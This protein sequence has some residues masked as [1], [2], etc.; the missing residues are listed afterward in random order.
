[1]QNVVTYSTVIDVP[2]PDLRL[3]PGMTANVN[4]E[5]ARRTNALR[6]PNAALRFRP[7]KDIF[8]ALKQPMPEELNRGFGRGNRAGQQNAGGPGGGGAPGA[9]SGA[10]AP[11]PE[12]P[13]APNAKAG[14]PSKNGKNASTGSGQAPASKNTPAGQN[15]Q[16]QQG[17][18]N[19]QGA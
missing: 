18:Q 1:V 8:D 10:G 9:Q 6:V 16:N 4:I 13:A 12:M 2:N 7:T 17:G 5:I 15:A 19:A 11:N 14:D 3:K